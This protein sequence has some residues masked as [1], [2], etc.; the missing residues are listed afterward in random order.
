MDMTVSG[1]TV[2]GQRRLNC[3][4]IMHKVRL[5]T[6]CNT[7]LCIASTLILCQCL[8]QCNEALFIGDSLNPTFV[9]YVL[10]VHLATKWEC[11]TFESLFKLTQHDIRSCVS[12]SRQVE[13]IEAFW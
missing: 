1:H 13:N 2:P 12:M 11:H 4:H 9:S 10:L 5:R 6:S 8:L 7:S 3:A